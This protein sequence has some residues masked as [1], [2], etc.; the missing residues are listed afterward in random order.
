MDS[1]ILTN[2]SSEKMIFAKHT[3]VCLREKL[4]R[5]TVEEEGNRKNTSFVS[6]IY[7]LLHTVYVSILLRYMCQ[8]AT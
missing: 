3:Y 8:V 5:N 7:L 6:H 1:S 4:V 2:F